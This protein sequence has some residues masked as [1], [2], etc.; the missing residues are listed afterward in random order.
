VLPLEDVVQAEAHLLRGR[1]RVRG[2]GRGRVRVRVSVSVRVRVRARVRVGPRRT[3]KYGSTEMSDGV[4]PR[5][6]AGTPSLRTMLAVYRK[7]F[8]VSRSDTCAIRVR[9]DS[10]GKHAIIAVMPAKP[11]AN[12]LI[13]GEG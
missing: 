11:P 7:R 9:T 1:V 13:E 3:A 4:R 10:S 5:Y 2:R 12:R 6:R 8:L